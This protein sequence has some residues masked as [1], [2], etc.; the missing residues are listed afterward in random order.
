MGLYFSGKHITCVL[1]SSTIQ[2]IDIPTT[3]VLRSYDNAKLNNTHT[4]CYLH[5]NTIATGGTEGNVTLW[6]NR[7]HSKLHIKPI[8]EFKFEGRVHALSCSQG[9]LLMVALQK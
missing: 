8:K 1:D 7:L 3:K 5:N 9:G 2:V 4:L 6:D